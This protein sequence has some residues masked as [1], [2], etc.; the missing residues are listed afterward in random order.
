ML[1]RS[2]SGVSTD[3]QYLELGRCGCF[4]GDW[5]DTVVPLDEWVHLAVTVDTNQQIS[6]FINGIFDSTWGGSGLNLTLGPNI[7]LADN[8]IRSF[9]GTLE[10]V[11]IWS[12]VLSQSEIQWGM[13]RTPDVAD[14]NLVAYWP[15]NDDS[16]ATA[17]NAAIATGSACDGTLVNSPAWVLSTVPFVPD[18]TTGVATGV[19]PANATLT[20]T[21]NPCPPRSGSSGARTPTTATSPPPKVSPP[22]TPFWTLPPCSPI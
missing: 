3:P 17:T 5:S 12:R 22:P 9:N 1:V 14:T 13:Y 20:G 16:G 10:E 6:Y 2:E 7:T 4:N 15:M 21:I 11:Q 8:N 18:A 19:C